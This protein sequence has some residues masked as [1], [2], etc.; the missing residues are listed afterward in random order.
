MQLLPKPSGK[1]V[2][3]S[4]VFDGIEL[5]SLPPSGMQ[6][7]RGGKIGYIFQEP[8]TSLNPVLTIGQQIGEAI[9]LHSDTIDK[10]CR[11]KNYPALSKKLRDKIDEISVSL[12]KKV[13][14]PDPESRLMTYPHQF[15]GGMR[16]RVMIAMTLAGNPDLLIA[17]EPTT[18]L[19]V[20]IQAQ[21][22]ELIKDIR[23]QYGM[24]YI[25]ISHDF[26]VI[27]QMCEET[28]VMYAG[29][30]VECGSTFEIYDN[31]KHPYTQGLINSIPS[32]KTEPKKPLYTIAGMPPR[33]GEQINGC[34]FRQ[35]CSFAHEKCASTPPLVKIDGTGRQAACFLYSE[36]GG[37]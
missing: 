28:I 36:H 10:K 11:N 37:M 5:S 30:V 13:G 20:T 31:P 1:I 2:S 14:V 32:E 21:I 9:L 17:D 7:F 4:I 15:S 29:R 25:F 16:Q 33:Q 26:G 18:A 3:G 12:L 24:S 19:D 27:R 22:L 8:M 34:A 6:K 35:R 23:R